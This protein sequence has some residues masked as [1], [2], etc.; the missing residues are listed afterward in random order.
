MKGGSHK[1]L[2]VA[3][4]WVRESQSERAS[5]RESDRDLVSAAGLVRTNRQH[6]NPD[7]K[8]ERHARAAVWGVEGE[9]E[10]LAHS[11]RTHVAGFRV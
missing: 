9:A 7:R 6:R 4:E 10:I 1:A 5:E 11:I 3:G 2:Q 8:S